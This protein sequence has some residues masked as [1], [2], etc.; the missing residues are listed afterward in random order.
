PASS[1]TIIYIGY[2]PVS[3]NLLNSVNDGEA[4]QLS[5]VYGEY[6][7]GANVF[8][9]YFNALYPSSDFFVQS[10][11]SMSQ[12]VTS[13]ASST[14]CYSNKVYYIKS[15]G[16]GARAFD[17]AYSKPIP[18]QAAIILG[19]NIDTSIS[20]EGIV[21]LGAASMS[22]S[23]P[24]IDYATTNGTS[25]SITY[26]QNGGFSSSSAANSPGP[27]FDGIE[28]EYVPGASDVTAQ[29]VNKTA[30]L[31]YTNVIPSSYS[32]GLY[33]GIA[34]ATLN[35]Q[36]LDYTS[37]MA[38]AAYPPNGVMPSV[39]FMS[40]APPTSMTISTSTGTYS[41]NTS[42]ETDNGVDYL[43]SNPSVTAGSSFS[44]NYWKPK[45]VINY[46]NLTITNSQTS[47]TPA[48]FQQLVNIPNSVYNT[49]A[50]SELNNTVFFNIS[51]GGVIPSW[52][53][54]YA[55]STNAMFWLRF[56]SGIPAS[57][58]IKS[59]GVGFAKASTNLLNNSSDGE[60]PQ[61]SSA[62]G[63]YDDG[64]DVFNFYDNFAGTSLGDEWQI[65]NQGNGTYSV[66]NGLTLSEKAFK[67]QIDVVT[68]ASFSSG[69]F[70]GRI[71]SQNYGSYRGTGM[72]FDTVLPTDSGGQ[73]DGYFF[74]ASDNGR[75][76]DADIYSVVSGAQTS[77]GSAS[78]NPP[79]TPYLMTVEWPNT[80]NEAW[81]N[82]YNTYIT[83]TNTAVSK[84]PSYLDLYAGSDGSNIGTIS[85]SYV[86]VRAYPP[87]GA[88]PSVSFSSVG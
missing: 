31:S 72:A 71:T 13:C 40:I 42:S 21:S 61:L 77:V 49:Y 48:P 80:G 28:L 38:A 82:N 2:A 62:Y 9:D 44:F 6:D 43:F 86:R 22:T 11:Y 87:N 60:A 84:G 63:K 37:W 78:V 17:V 46:A 33:M 23:T 4:P 74:M 65:F 1:S 3:T 47:A 10:G 15:T 88:M 75:T 29:L 59:V 41:A 5:P 36:E 73:Q 35:V 39:T 54:S 53:E 34:T 7:D 25:L 8:N 67:T 27:N 69:I 24:G 18:D 76:G 51:T 52:L 32:A 20:T 56:D 85:F 57:T 55:Y 68:I 12:V 14:N 19:S 50:N 45:S 58:S 79:S 64:A 26:L 81:L 66:N 16:T 70:E 83:S 30:T